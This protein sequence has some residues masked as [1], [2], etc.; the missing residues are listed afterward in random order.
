MAGEDPKQPLEVDVSPIDAPES[1]PLHEDHHVSS[2]DRSGINNDMANSGEDLQAFGPERHTPA[3]YEQIPPGMTKLNNYETLCCQ[4]EGCPATMN[5]LHYLQGNPD[6][7]AWQKTFLRSGPLLG[8]CALMFVM[9]SI[10]AAAIVLSLADAKAVETWKVQPSVYLSVFTGVGNKVLAFAAAKGAIITHFS[11]LTATSMCA[12]VILVDGILLQ[13]A[14]T[15]V[16]RSLRMPVKLH[17]VL[18]PEIPNNFTGL[19]AKLDLQNDFLST[20][21]NENFAPVWRDWVARDPIPSPVEDCPGTCLT[22]VQA[23]AFSLTSC[24]VMSSEF[25]DLAVIAAANGSEDAY[26]AATG[27]R[28]SHCRSRSPREAAEREAIFVDIGMID[29]GI[30]ET[31]AG[32]FTQRRCVLEPAIA[33]CQVTVHNDSTVDINALEPVILSLADNNVLIKVW[34]NA[35]WLNSP[36]PFEQSLIENPVFLYSNLGDESPRIINAPV[37]RDPW[38][39]VLKRLDELMFRAAV[40]ATQTLDEA[41]VAEPSEPSLTTRQNVDGIRIDAQPVFETRRGFFWGASAVQIVCV[42]LVTITYWKYWA[43]E[44]NKSLSSLELAKA[45]DAPLLRDARPNL[46]ARRLV[47]EVGDRKVRYGLVEDKVTGKDDE[48]LCKRLVFDEEHRVQS[49][50]DGCSTPK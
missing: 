14:T 12:L 26:P 43:L 18:P 21:M 45:F 11:I 9:L 28:S 44:R 37:L 42:V 16:Q 34:E 38:N 13:S 4:T 15:T 47:E 27:A 22:T 6:D 49:F 1:L 50:S 31:A 24:E 41:A 25:M 3:P 30:S 29:Q 23:P 40:L 2:L 39:E 48:K 33:E 5:P 32:N 7:R 17:A 36:G 35:T 20:A 46:S 19:A 8:I 10:P